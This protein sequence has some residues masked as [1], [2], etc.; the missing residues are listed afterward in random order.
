MS[1]K[2]YTLADHEA[3]HEKVEREEA[4]E[5]AAQKERVAKESARRR[6]LAAGGDPDVFERQWGGR[7]G[8][9]AQIQAEE[10]YAR[11]KEAQQQDT[12]ARERQRRSRTGR[13]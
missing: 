8:I 4:K 5:A 11:I 6:W 10:R 7:D 2:K 13:L 9:Y 3:Y 12:A 1:D